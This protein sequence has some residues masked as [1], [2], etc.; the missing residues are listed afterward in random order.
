MLL[1]MSISDTS[2]ENGASCS[3]IEVYVLI[4]LDLR[5]GCPEHLSLNIT[6]QKSG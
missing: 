3:C 2:L 6:T 1:D 5:K 4:E